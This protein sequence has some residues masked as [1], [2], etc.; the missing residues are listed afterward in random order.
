MREVGVIKNKI[1]NKLLH[2]NAKKLRIF[3]ARHFYTSSKKSNL[4]FFKT[5]KTSEAY[6]MIKSMNKSVRLELDEIIIP[7]E[8]NYISSSDIIM[9]T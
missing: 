1:Q 7:K 6:L 3:K 4:F 9:F 8:R 2:F 5:N